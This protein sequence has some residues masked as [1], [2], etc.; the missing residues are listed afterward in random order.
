MRLSAAAANI[1]D[2]E[3][4]HVGAQGLAA[5]ADLEDTVRVAVPIAGRVVRTTVSIHQAAAA[6]QAATAA[7]LMTLSLMVGAVA[8]AL[9]AAVNLNA[10]VATGGQI[11]VQDSVSITVAQ[12]DLLCVRY[13]SPTY[14][15]NP[16]AV[17]WDVTLLIEDPND[18]WAQSLNKGGSVAWRG[19]S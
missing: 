14:D 3:T 18:V 6:T 19:V 16:T 11:T 10:I 5:L 2:A 8:T 17:G 9:D 1:G 15:T 4:R 7:Q 13:L 12:G